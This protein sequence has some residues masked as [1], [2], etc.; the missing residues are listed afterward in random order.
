VLERDMHPTTARLY[1]ALERA[2][3][4]DPGFR[5]DLAPRRAAVIVHTAALGLVMLVALG[6]AVHDPLAHRTD[7]LAATLTA[8][9]CGGTGG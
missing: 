2:F 1:A 6:E 9:L 8:M 7:D 3:E 5:H 4:G